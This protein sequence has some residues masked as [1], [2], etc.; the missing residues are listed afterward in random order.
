MPASKPKIVPYEKKPL[1]NYEVVPLRSDAITVAAVQM[2]A[3]KVDPRNPK[4]GIRKKLAHI[5]DCIDLV[6]ARQHID[7]VCFPEFSIQ[8]SACRIW[9]R[10]DILRLAIE[11][12]GEE[13]ELLGKKARE[14]NCYIEMAGY[15]KEKEW[16][17][18]FFNCS[19]LIAPNGK[20]IHR[21]WKAITSQGMLEIATTVHDV[22][23]EFIERY[24]WDAV[25]PVARTDIGNIATFICSEGFIPETARAFA[26]KGAE[27]LVRSIGGGAVYGMPTVGDPMFTMRAY[28][29][30][31]NTYGILCNNAH[32]Q[33][34][35]YSFEESGAGETMIIDN[36]GEVM[37]RAKS[38]NE[39]A[40][41]AVIP[42]GVF[43]KKRSIPVIRKELYA[44]VYEQYVG[45]FPP[46]LYLKYLPKDHLDGLNYARRN[47]RW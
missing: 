15:T 43:R 34:D 24:G 45:K 29:M 14:Y 1:P 2:T 41:Y 39:T 35:F 33:T 8:G 7:L 20:V 40:V 47:A 3:S 46:N 5:I 31:N 44:P 32:G 38:P 6:Q 10:K 28:S 16:P 23:D 27:L 25:W 11:M 37:Q 12:P 36:T 9:T 13:T 26:F 17:G 22:L 21:H 18:H 30:F 19:F 4:P 42:I